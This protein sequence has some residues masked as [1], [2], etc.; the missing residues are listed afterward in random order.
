MIKLM[1]M[2]STVTWTERNTK[3]TGRK[4]SN[5][6]MDSKHGLMVLGTMVNTSKE[7]NMERESSPGQMAV[8]TTASSSK[9][10]SKEKASIIGPMDVSMMASGRIIRWRATASSRGLMA[11]DM[12]DP[13]LTIKRKAMVTSTGQMVVSMKE[14]GKMESSMESEHTHLLVGRRSKASGPTVR[15]FT[16]FQTPKDNNEICTRTRNKYSME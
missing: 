7:R 10:I 11:E 16:G 12:R 6:V 8:P 13:M 14:D 3:D 4:T 1:A 2:V 15:D 5:T 9:I